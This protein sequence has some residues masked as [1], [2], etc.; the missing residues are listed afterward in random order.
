MFF[1]LR[2]VTFV[3]GT[4]LV[5][6][7]ALPLVIRGKPTW[8]GPSYLDYVQNDA[9][10]APVA[11]AFSESPFPALA[12][13]NGFIFLSSPFIGKEL[14]EYQYVKVLDE[15]EGQYNKGIQ[16][17]KY[18]GEDAILKILP[19]STT[20]F[21]FGEALALRDVGSLLAS[22]KTSAGDSAVIMKYINGLAFYRIPGNNGLEVKADAL[23]AICRNVA[24]IA[25]KKHVYHECVAESEADLLQNCILTGTDLQPY[26][27]NHAGN[28]LFEIGADNK[29]KSAQVLDFG[30][31]GVFRVVGE[32]TEKDVVSLLVLS[33][34]EEVFDY[35][36]RTVRLLYGKLDALS[37][38]TL[39]LG[40]AS[41]A[42]R[43]S[44]CI[45]TS[46]YY[47]V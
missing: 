9:N 4:L 25:V 33:L 44:K 32:V 23:K 8:M 5:S 22:G 7:L 37:E 24:D 31:N 16:L 46:R 29:V 17:V 39:R 43:R 30:P 20:N 6:S 36:R 35:R 42:T 12:G 47:L 11:G 2:S 13:N 45:G 34:K 15:D 26:S 10:R 21:D 28:V 19:T 38:I 14:P 3:L 40:Q 18:Q 27:D 41:Q 1:K